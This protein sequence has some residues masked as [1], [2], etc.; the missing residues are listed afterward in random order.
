MSWLA[1]Y[2]SFEYLCYGST[3]IGNILILSVRGSSSYVVYRRQIL[4][5]K[6]GPRAEGLTLAPLSTTIVVFNLFN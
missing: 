5:Y 1:L 4:T 2:D 6:D 3:A